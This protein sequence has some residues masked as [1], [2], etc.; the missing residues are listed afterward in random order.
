[1][2]TPT[3]QYIYIDW[4]GSTEVGVSVSSCFTSSLAVCCDAGTYLCQRRHCNI[5]I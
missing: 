4:C 2:S 1:M 5:Y 3:L